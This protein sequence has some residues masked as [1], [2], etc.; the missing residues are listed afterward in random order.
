MNKLRKFLYTTLAILAI[1]TLSIVLTSCSN[2]HNFTKNISISQID[3][4]NYTIIFS[5]SLRN[6][7]SFSTNKFKSNLETIV[8][9]EGTIDTCLQVKCTKI[10]YYEGSEGSP[11]YEYTLITSDGDFYITLSGDKDPVIK[12][13]ETITLIFDRSMLIKSKKI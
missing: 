3:S 12:Q 8:I 4:T 11:W 13:W 1:I 7:K 10:Y 9:T 6:V 5:N 2:A